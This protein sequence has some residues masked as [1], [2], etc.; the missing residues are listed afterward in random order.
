MLSKSQKT[1]AAFFIFAIFV[2]A[3]TIFL[4]E[5]GHFFAAKLVGFE[6]TKLSFDH[7]YFGFIDRDSIT[8]KLLALLGGPVSSILQVLAC[9]ILLKY[10]KHPIFYIIGIFSQGRIM[11]FLANPA[12]L[13]ESKIAIILDIPS[14]IPI[15]ISTA[16]FIAAL[17]YF[18]RKLKTEGTK[19]LVVM[20]IIIAGLLVGS[21]LWIGVLGPMLLPK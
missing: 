2:P 12:T 13:D 20:P 16:T 8:P 17:I 4:H 10:F 19:L 3:I 5:L 21:F 7:T 14:W 11:K 18:G 15:A 9:V 6:G 1:L